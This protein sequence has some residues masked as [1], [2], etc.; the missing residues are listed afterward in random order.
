MFF[1]NCFK[2]IQCKKKEKNIK[3]KEGKDGKESKEV[4][5][6]R[7]AKVKIPPRSIILTNPKQQLG[8]R[9]TRAVTADSV[10]IA[11]Y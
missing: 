5:Y 6:V 4:K 11:S 9:I 3:I 10:V 8:M 1:I 7:L 2:G